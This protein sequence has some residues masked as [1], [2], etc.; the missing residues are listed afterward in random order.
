MGSTSG[1]IK[2]CQNCARGKI[3]CIKTSDSSIYV[4]ALIKS[5]IFGPPDLVTIPLRRGRKAPKFHLIRDMEALEAKVDQLL[6]RVV[7]SQQTKH[8]LDVPLA[9]SDP[10]LHSIPDRSRDV[11][12]RGIVRFDDAVTLLESFRKTLMPCFPFIFIAPEVTLAQLRAEKPLLL[13]AILKGSSYKNAATQQIL[14]E[15]FQTA[16]ADQM[17]FAHNPSMDVLLGLLVALGWLQHQS[18]H[19]RFSSYLHLAWSIVGDLRLDRLSETQSFYSRMAMSKVSSDENSSRHSVN[20]RRRALIGCY[21]LSSS[22]S[23][24]LQKDRMMTRLS[25]VEKHALELLS[26]AEISSDRCLI[27]LVRLQGISERIDDA[28]VTTANPVREVDMHAFQTEIDEYR[29]NLPATFSDNSLLQFHLH[30]LQ[31]F[32]CHACLFDKHET[33]N[34]SA[35]S[36]PR[37]HADSGLSPHLQSGHQSLDLSPFQVEFL[38][39]GMSEAKKFFDYV[40]TFAPDTFRLISYTQWLQTGFNLVLSCKL[41]VTGAKYAPRSPHVRALCSALNMPH[42]LRAVLQRMQW[43]SKD[44]VTVDGKKHS[45]HFYEAWLWHIL[46]W[47]EQKYHLVP[48]EDT[49]QIPTGLPDGGL[50]PSTS[51]SQDFPLIGGN[52]GATQD[53]TALWPDFFWNISTDDI[54]NGY[55]GFPDMPY[56]TLQPGYDVPLP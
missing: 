21:M 33:A 27:Q 3:R 47:F 24:I 9:L 56:P 49:A 17:I 40:F 50:G 35:S 37:S 4:A 8:Q 12:D 2:T 6:G 34:Y 11:I 51:T 1:H 55:M 52:Y 14:E 54:L 48:S 45:K 43:L 23:T 39:R 36:V 41:A 26:N 20:E 53:D 16:V 13:L 15:T 19:E 42:I 25:Y 7:N 31:L 46:E 5:A 44:R 29:T 32:L 28:V 22:R 30:T 10:G 38:N 18:Q